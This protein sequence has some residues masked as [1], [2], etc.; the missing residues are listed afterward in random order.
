MTNRIAV[1]FAFLLLSACAGSQ[2][3][4][5]AFISAAG[6]LRPS[7]VL[8]TMSV[9]G[10]PKGS[11]PDR[12]FASGIVVASGPW[13]SDM[14]TVAH[15]IDSAWNIR[16]TIDNKQVARARIIGRDTVRD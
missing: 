3:P 4:E 7:V 12:E 1:C 8:L 9:P 11:A 6:R 14:L 16:V 10:D 13:G 5:D 2:R 15:A